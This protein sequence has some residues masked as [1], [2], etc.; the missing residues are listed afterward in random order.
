MLY[1]MAKALD[2][3]SL[4]GD[5]SGWKPFPKYQDREAW[6]S[7]SDEI[8][9]VWMETAEKYMDFDWPALRYERYLNIKRHG[10][11]S[12]HWYAFVMRRGL[13][14]SFLMAECL[15][16][17]GR[18]MDQIINGVF[19]TCEETSWVQGL[20]IA[21]KNYAV[22][23]E[24]DNYVDLCASESAQLLAWVMYLVGEPLDAEDKGIRDRVNREVLRRVVQPYLDINDYWWLGYTEDRINNWN[25]WCNMNVLQAAM[26]LDYPA[27][28]KVAV[29]EKITA[30]LDI[31]ID[32]YPD[33][34][35]CDEGPMY[36]GA[37]GQ[38]LGKC[39]DLLYGITGGRL[40]GSGIQKL[41]NIGTYYA[42]VHIHENWYVSYADGDARFDAA[43]VIY[44][45]GKLIK[46]EGLMRLGASAPL[47]APRLDNWFQA[48]DYLVTIFDDKERK[49]YGGGSPYIEKAVF[50][51]CQ[52]LCAR[53]K[54]GSPDGFF[55]SAKAGHNM[56]SHNHNDLGNFIVYLDGK[57]VFIDLGTE[58]YRTQTFSPRRFELWYLQ[59]QYHNC[60]TVNGVMQHDG[61]EYTASDVSYDLS[62]SC[63]RIR[64]NIA[65]AYTPDSKI[66]VWNRSVE[67]D[68]DAGA[69]LVRDAYE[70][71]GE[72]TTDF[73]FMTL[74][75]PVLEDGKL[76]V[77]C[78]DGSVATLSFD[79]AALSGKVE[80]IVLED[81]R[82]RK[83]W[84]DTIYR[85]TLS[86]K[87]PTAAATREFRITR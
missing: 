31:Y 72:S 65:G 36:W 54:G 43:A 68:R 61:G 70:T 9:A 30:S 56:E 87:A 38:G 85:T 58:E 28:L 26:L 66:R 77:D 6:E 57:P 42:K 34:G 41:I 39:I 80:K 46:D 86:D 12:S 22:P 1:E 73:H 29:V 37:A 52:I 19:A 50:E 13:L 17:K 81:A 84:G 79:A 44:R 67:L 16:G 47:S 25:P 2:L 51:D 14:G 48:Y 82:L 11:I 53:E 49:E 74:K 32:R 71:E 23:D 45:F 60:P 62:D 63:D 5:L 69:V 83:N 76:V 10:D 7:V 8:R 33:D 59:S 27:E 64:M 3:K 15:E 24:S 20:N 75:E 55:M 18:F 21:N 78:G 35:A 40:D 4:L